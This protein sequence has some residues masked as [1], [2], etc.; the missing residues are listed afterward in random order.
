M[1]RRVFEIATRAIFPE[2]IKF[3]YIPESQHRINAGTSS[4]GR[5]NSPDF[6]LPSHALD[7]QE[8]EHVLVL[9][10]SDCVHKKNNAK[11][12]RVTYFCD[13]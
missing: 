3:V 11:Q 2:H 4:S 5:G 7:T 1:S 6:R 13:V 10:F 9:E 8:R 12:R